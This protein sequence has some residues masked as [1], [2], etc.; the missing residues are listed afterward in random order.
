MSPQ[1]PQRGQRLAANRRQGASAQRPSSYST[2]PSELL[3]DYPVASTIL[4]FGVGLGVGVLIGQTVAS[5]LSSRAE[6]SQFSR[7]ES[8]G[9][10]ISDAVRNA[11]PEAISRHLAR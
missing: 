11:I 4:A 2:S 6:P 1:S 5:A 10:Q 3:D 9:T 7:L 8:L